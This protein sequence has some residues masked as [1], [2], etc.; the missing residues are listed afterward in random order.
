MTPGISRTL[1][2]QGAAAA[3]PL[4]REMTATFCGNAEGTESGL[5]RPIQ[6]PAS[7][8]PSSLASGFSFE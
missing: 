3:R 2:S 1:R 6:T 5:Y 4:F 8:S 7:T